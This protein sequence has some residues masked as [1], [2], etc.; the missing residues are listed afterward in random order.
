[1]PQFKQ[2]TKNRIVRLHGFRSED[3]YAEGPLRPVSRYERVISK[4]I[5]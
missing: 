4:E 5:R 3:Q 2:Q 1:M